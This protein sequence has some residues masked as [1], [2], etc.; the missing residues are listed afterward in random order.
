MPA[1]SCHSSRTKT[2]LCAM[3][4]QTKLFFLFSFSCCKRDGKCRKVEVW[5]Y[6]LKE[7]V[8][9]LILDRQ[10][11]ANLEA[12]FSFLEKTSGDICKACRK[13]LQQYRNNGKT[14]HH[15]SVFLAFNFVNIT[16]TCDVKIKIQRCGVQLELQMCHFYW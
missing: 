14:F 5:V 10:L 12:C 11:N 16:Y 6:N 8:S 9:E 3:A 7:K 13:A 4:V 15:V 1:H 2:K